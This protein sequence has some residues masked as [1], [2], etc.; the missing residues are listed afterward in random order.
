M[1]RSSFF[2]HPFTRHYIDETFGI[3]TSLVSVST[4]FIASIGTH[5][6]RLVF[7]PKRELKGHDADGTDRGPR[8]QDRLGQPAEIIRNLQPENPVMVFAPSV[9]RATAQRFLQGFPGLVTYA[10]KSNPDEAVI[11]T[12]AAAGVSGLRRRLPL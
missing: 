1:P 4:L 6:R 5:R 11:R 2:V 7:T 3:L 10:V 8:P 12:L 9:L